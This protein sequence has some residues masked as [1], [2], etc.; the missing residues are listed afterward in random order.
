MPAAT[1]AH[2]R[3]LSAVA[4]DWGEKDWVEGIG[5]GVSEDAGV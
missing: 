1:L 2:D 3:L 5:R 4:K